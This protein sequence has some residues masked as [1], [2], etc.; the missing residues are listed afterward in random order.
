MTVQMG[1]CGSGGRVYNGGSTG[2]EKLTWLR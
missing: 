1:D 2:P